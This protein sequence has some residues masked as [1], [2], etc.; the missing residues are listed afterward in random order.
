MGRPNDWEWLRKFA[1]SVATS[2]SIVRRTAFPPSFIS[3]NQHLEQTDSKQGLKA[4]DNSAWSWEVD[5]QLMQW[6]VTSP[7]QW[8]AGGKCMAYLWGSG[9]NGQIGEAGKLSYQTIYVK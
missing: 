1:L 3:R 2:E 8:Q 9:R 4:L 6:F 5:E 7:E